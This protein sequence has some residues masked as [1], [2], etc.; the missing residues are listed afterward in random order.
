MQQ[1]LCETRILQ[2]SFT[3]FLYTFQT[4]VLKP[5]FYFLSTADLNDQ[6]IFKKLRDIPLIEDL[7]I[8]KK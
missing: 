8:V 3:D 2:P 7:S 1:L 5:K 6:N 4:V